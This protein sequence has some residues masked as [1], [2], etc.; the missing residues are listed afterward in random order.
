MWDVAGKDVNDWRLKYAKSHASN[1]EDAE[2]EVLLGRGQPISCKSAINLC[3]I[4]LVS[5]RKYPKPVFSSSG[6]LQQPYPKI[7][8]LY[9]PPPFFSHPI[10]RIT[11][12][13]INL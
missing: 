2:G 9:N 11:F 8:P 7:S 5:T 12:I 4:D 6:H 1:S 3:L 10:H 13:I